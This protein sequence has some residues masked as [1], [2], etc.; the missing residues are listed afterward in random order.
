MIDTDKPFVLYAEC[1]IIYDGRAYSTLANGRYL[2][3]YKQDGSL[4]IHG[5]DL[6][7]PRNYQGPGS[8]LSYI[9]SKLISTNKKEKIIIDIN[10]I[11]EFQSLTDWSTAQISICRT[12]KEL[13]DRIYNNWK[14][15]FPGEFVLVQRE[16]KTDVGSIDVI[17]I[18]D[19]SEY[20]IVEVKRRKILIQDITQLKRYADCLRESGKVVHGYL[21]APTISSNAATYLE[22]NNFRLIEINFTNALETEK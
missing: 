12:E 17:G 16:F 15:Y 4:L 20:Y 5:G 11:I 19:K 7:K 21:A 6:C 2:I 9:D 1:S 10:E 22:R 14:Q 8:I 13:S 3:I 18:S